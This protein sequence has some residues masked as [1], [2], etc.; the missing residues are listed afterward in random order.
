MILAWGV[1]LGL[2]LHGREIWWLLAAAA[3]LA[4]LAADFLS[5]FVHFL[6]DNVGTPKT[7][8]LG[9]TFIQPFREHHANPRAITRHDF[10]EVNGNN[11]MVIAPVLMTLTYAL[12]AASGPWVLGINFFA[13][14][15][16]LG[17]F[18]TNQI[19]KWAHEPS[20]PKAVALL[21]RWHL[22]LPPAHHDVHHASPFDT[23]YCITCGWLNPVLAK[24]QVFERLTRLAQWAG[25]PLFWWRVS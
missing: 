24:Y 16:F 5:G 10:V 2:D 7:P 4:F 14:C 18:L 17:I 3:P 25:R 12:P 22:I 15:L 21:Q 19:H 9:P 11:C 23:Y 13:L 8:W 1:W 20:P 6:A